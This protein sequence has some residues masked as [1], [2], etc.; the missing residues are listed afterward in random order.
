MKK[1]ILIILSLLILGCQNVKVEEKHTDDIKIC[2]QV[3]TYAKNPETMNCEEFPTPCAVP[4]DWEI[5]ENEI[6]A[7]AVRNRTY[8]VKHVG[9]GQS[10]AE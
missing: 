4:K 3:I 1:V 6:T 8:I 10:F 9:I 2:A 7:D 5:C